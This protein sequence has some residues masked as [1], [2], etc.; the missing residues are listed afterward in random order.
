MLTQTD[1]AAAIPP[2]SASERARNRRRAPVRR[3]RLG[4]AVFAIA[5]G[6]TVVGQASWRSLASSK[7]Q[8]QAASTPLLLDKPRFTGVL[9]DGRPFLITAD[10]A[11]RDPN[12]QDLVRL[13]APMLVRGYGQPDASQATAKSGVYRE[14]AHTLLLTQDVKITNGEGYEFDAPQAL[15]DM[16]TGEVSGNGGVAGTGPNASTRANTYSVKDK[17]DR[18]I[19]NGRVRTRLE[20][21]P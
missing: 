1:G 17:G 18:V 6:V 3:L 21:R 5:V 11:E 13:S 9:K 14:A 4:L 2:L 7:L 16:R 19:L 10:R 8:T 20:P 15:I 12:D